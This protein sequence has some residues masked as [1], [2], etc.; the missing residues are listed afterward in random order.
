MATAT[1]EEIAEEMR[2]VLDQGAHAVGAVTS[3][4][5]ADKVAVSHEP[6]LPEDGTMVAEDLR[7]AGVLEVAA[8]AAV[9]GSMEYGATVTHSGDGIEVAGTLAGT[10]GDGAR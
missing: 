8:Y 6:P 4:Y 7:T 10:V 3:A 9:L 5:Y 1:V 2:R